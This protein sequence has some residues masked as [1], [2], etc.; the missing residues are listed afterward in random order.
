M[1]RIREV[2]TLGM[3]REKESHE[4]LMF[5]LSQVDLVISS[6]IDSACQIHMLKSGAP[7]G[8]R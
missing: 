3:E 2:L 4:Q 6:F 1:G 5:S 8:W 7:V